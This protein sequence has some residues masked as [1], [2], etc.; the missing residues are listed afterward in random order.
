MAKIMVYL[1]D[2]LYERADPWKKQL[3]FSEVFRSALS[4]KLR[5]F[6]RGH[7]EMLEIG[8]QISAEEKTDMLERLG[9]EKRQRKAKSYEQAF[10]HGVS[11][12]KRAHYSE[13]QRLSSLASVSPK[14]DDLPEGV[15]V[16]VIEDFAETGAPD[17]QAYIDGWFKGVD[18]F[19]DWVEEQLAEE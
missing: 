1:P 9:T 10:I 7:A 6:E 14:L 16:G 12:A 3:N 5:A 18:T 13:L 8:S 19:G 17:L 15:K 4:E 11:W 2:E